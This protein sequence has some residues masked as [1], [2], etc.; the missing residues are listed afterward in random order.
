MDAS[1]E[2]VTLFLS[3]ISENLDMQRK[4]IADE[5]EAARKAERE[6][7]E[8]EANRRSD[9]YIK[10]ETAH[11]LAQAKRAQSHFDKEL[12]MELAAARTDIVNRVFDAVE[13]KL[14]AF[15]QTPDY[16]GFL[17]KSAARLQGVLGEQAMLL[18][19][20]PADLCYKELLLAAVGAS[21]EVVADKTIVLGGC[22]AR[23]S[24]G[25]LVLDDTL[26]ARLS[27][28]RQHFYESSGLS[29]KLFESEVN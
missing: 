20:R 26:D 5:I 27:E 23:G 17:E 6:K 1:N 12:R 16:T 9:A 8:L 10:A 21:A 3:A 4:E 13:K 2:K 29:V 24:S 19:V 14:T 28:Q 11:I 7:A 22:K 18:S 15:T 25:N